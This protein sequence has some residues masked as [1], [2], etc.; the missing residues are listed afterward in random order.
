V[1][2]SSRKYVLGKDIDL[3]REVVRDGRGRRITSKRAEKIAEEVVIQVVGRP[4]LTGP[5]RISPEVK[6]R[7]PAK[8]KLALEREAKR[9]GQTPSALIRQALE[10]FLDSA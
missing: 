6:A 9:Q 8:L 10:E 7:V 5:S 4:S 3:D 2:N 1:A